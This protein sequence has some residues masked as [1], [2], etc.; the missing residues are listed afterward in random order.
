MQE[1]ASKGARTAVICNVIDSTAAREARD[2]IYTHAG[3]EI[4]VAST[5][6]FTCQLATIYLLTIYFGTLKGTMSGQYRSKLAKGLIE[7]PLK[8][9]TALGRQKH[10]EN[11]A[12]KY[13]KKS[14]FLYIGR[15]INYPL[16]LEGALKLKETSYIH[17]E[18]YPSGEM[19]HGPI[20]LI[21]GEIPIVAIANKSSV[22]EKMI[23]NIQELNARDGKVIAIATD[24]DKRIAEIAEDV[25]YLP[26]VPEILSPILNTIPLQLLAYHI[27][28]LRGCDIDQ[29][30]NLAKSVTVE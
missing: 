6:A 18:G 20:A 29:P 17:A 15:H 24:N 11:I 8:I 12:H 25:I 3:P 23:S 4:G 19:K 21:D 10:I 9:K 7:L 27:A 30:R 1:A 13:F 28:R 26:E 14:N 2:V 16:A 5:K 22:Y